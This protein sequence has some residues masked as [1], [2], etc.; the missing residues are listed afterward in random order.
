M[1]HSFNISEE[2]CINNKCRVTR[3]ELHG[4]YFIPND[5]NVALFIL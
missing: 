5:S 3:F 4:I 1:Y 2:T